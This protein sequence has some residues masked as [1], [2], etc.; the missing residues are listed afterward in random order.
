MV[1]DVEYTREMGIDLGGGLTPSTCDTVVW[2]N[3]MNTLLAPYIYSYSVYSGVSCWTVNP[4]QRCPSYIHWGEGNENIF[5]SRRI[6]GHASPGYFYINYWKLSLFKHFQA[7][8]E[9]N[10]TLISMYRSTLVPY[11]IG[12]RLHIWSAV[13]LDGTMFDLLVWQLQS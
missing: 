7:S 4:V 3:P 11:I 13:A 5:Q 10:V 1:S 8:V 12:L 9:N 2:Q 6:W